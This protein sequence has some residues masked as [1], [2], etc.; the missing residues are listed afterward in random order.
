MELRENGKTNPFDQREIKCPYCF[1][2]F[3]H[4]KVEFRTKPVTE[5][6]L[7]VLDAKRSDPDN[8]DA[9]AAQKRYKYYFEN[10]RREKDKTWTDYWKD[11]GFAENAEL[12][13]NGDGYDEYRDGKRN[14]VL[15]GDTNPRIV[16]KGLLL[17]LLRDKDGFVTGAVDKR[18]VETH[19]R[20][21][22]HCHN[23]L[24]KEYG[25]NDVKFVS[26]VGISGSGKTVMLSQLIE[27][28]EDYAV[29]VGGTVTYDSEDSAR[30]F[31]MRYKVK[32]G[33]TLPIGTREHF[34][35]PIFLRF[36]RKTEQ[37]RIE[38]CMVVIYDIAGESCIKADGLE[39]YGPFVRNAD[40]II[41]L[42]DPGQIS[43]FGCSNEELERPTAVLNAMA[44]AFLLEE[45]AASRVPLALAYSKSDMLRNVSLDD[46]LKENSNIFR[47]IR[48]NSKVRGF[49]LDEFRNINFEVETLTRKYSET[50]YQTIR[51]K[52]TTC[53]FFAFSA[54]G[55][56]TEQKETEDGRSVSVL[57]Q[58][59]Q[60]MRLEEPLL[61]IM[62]RWGLL[63][64]VEKD[65]EPKS[66]KKSAVESFEGVFSGFLKKGKK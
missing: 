36:S 32:G 20:I 15:S 31:I 9:E 61:W 30:K 29:K 18:G 27:N 52:F 44:R 64:G 65:T 34:S 66:G 42:V 41:L 7:E 19:Y 4:N 38:K 28:I 50:L 62:Y 48:Y 53:G 57:K 23:R 26:V 49:M 33:E 1:K 25:K 45:D 56:S 58:H 22:P 55:S 39:T 17:E 2:T 46:D 6:E 51:D 35:P 24:P 11:L 54:L 43:A 14:S 3:F 60:P 16:K 12:Y 47:D 21:C 10:Y 37:D 8:P 40:G 5:E 59:V 13:E 63:R